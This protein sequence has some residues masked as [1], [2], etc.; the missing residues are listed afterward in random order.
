MASG[1]P[2][3]QDVTRPW[4]GI[5]H[6]LIMEEST[7]NVGLGIS[8]KTGEDFRCF[9]SCGGLEL[10]F[11]SLNPDER[12]KLRI[13]LFSI[14]FAL[15]SNWMTWAWNG[16][17]RRSSSNHCIAVISSSLIK[18]QQTALR[19]RKEQIYRYERVLTFDDS[20]NRVQVISNRVGVLV[21][22]FCTKA[23]NTTPSCWILCT[24][25]SLHY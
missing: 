14:T 18:T 4:N 25:S 10:L 15:G 6:D 3:A 21:L 22:R 19:H 1:T 5:A 20:V 12:W 17:Q 23:S 11:M 2:S 8:D 24:S 13:T 9:Q 16:N 7:L